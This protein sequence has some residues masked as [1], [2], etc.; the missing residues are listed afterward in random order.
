MKKEKEVIELKYY[1]S[2][3]NIKDSNSGV[4]GSAYLTTIHPN[5]NSSI[6]NHSLFPINS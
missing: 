3:D 4:A 1:N 6:T 5:Y 2:K